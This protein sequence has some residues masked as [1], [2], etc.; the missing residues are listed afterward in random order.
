MHGV[1]YSKVEN[2]IPFVEDGTTYRL[3]NNTKPEYYEV[4][5][6]TWIHGGI[7]N[8]TGFVKIGIIALE[9]TKTQ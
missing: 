9:T 7:D 8:F 1:L 2:V 3:P 4:N 5:I 6:W